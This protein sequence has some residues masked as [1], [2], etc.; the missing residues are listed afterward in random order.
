MADELLLTP[1]QRRWQCPTCDKQHVT[2]GPAS[3][4][5]MHHCP[6]LR[7]IAVP[8][9]EVFETELNKSAQRHVVVEWG[10]YVGDQLVRRDGE[11][12]PV[13]AVRTERADGSNDVVVFPATA[14]ASS[15]R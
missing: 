3:E 9:V 8:Y 14:T 13:S 4:Q 2:S 10:D 11:G 5:P 12:R 7:G 1:V 6:A 15:Q